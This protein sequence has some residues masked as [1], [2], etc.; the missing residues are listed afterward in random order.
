[1]NDG[2]KGRRRGQRFPSTAIHDLILFCSTET[3]PGM[4]ICY[5]GEVRDAGR[6]EEDG[7][8]GVE[9]VN[10][11]RRRERIRRNNIYEALV[12]G[13]Q[14]VAVKHSSSPQAVAVLIII[15]TFCS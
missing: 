2:A 4:R 8:W 5:E 12:G 14:Q 15:P 1:M 7:E 11:T 6:D 10:R 13:F 3:F 9:E